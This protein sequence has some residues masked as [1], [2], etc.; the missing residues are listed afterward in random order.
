MRTLRPILLGLISL[1]IPLVLMMTS[2]RLVMSRLYLNLEYN[3]PGFPADPYGFTTEDRL[4]WSRFAL[5]YLYNDAGPEFLG[6]LRFPDGQPLFNQR[7]VGHMLDVKNLVQLM[8]VVW[9]LL[10]AGLAILGLIA[11]RTGW[12]AD[13][14]QAVSNG[15]WVT[16]GLIAAILVFVLISFQQLF[17]A[18]HRIF[19]EGDTWLF[20]YS[21]TLIRLF[22]LRFWQDGFILVGLF[23]AIGG[24][25]LALAGRRLARR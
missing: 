3:L 6:D 24:L 11:W 7:E 12:M 15:G 4:Y 25:I 13:F 16:L 10:L 20:Y 18:F 23:T 5:D 2:I 1:A 19:F 22:P 17:T 9:P 14:W 21:D 8:L